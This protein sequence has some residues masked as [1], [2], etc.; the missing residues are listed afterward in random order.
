MTTGESKARAASRELPL[1]S[2]PWEKLRYASIYQLPSKANRV[3]KERARLNKDAKF[4]LSA[5]HY[6]MP[7]ATIRGRVASVPFALSRGAR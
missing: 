1:H 6:C 7:S 3:S 4:V 2:P 5:D